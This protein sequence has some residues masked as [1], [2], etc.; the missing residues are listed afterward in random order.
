MA[1]RSKTATRSKRNAPEEAGNEGK[2]RSI[3]VSFNGEVP[4]DVLQFIGNLKKCEVKFVAF[5]AATVGKGM[6][7]KEK[8]TWI[9]TNQVSPS[10]SVSDWLREEE[11]CYHLRPN[12]C[13]LIA[14]YACMRIS[15]EIGYVSKMFDFDETTHEDPFGAFIKALIEESKK[16]KQI[17]LTDRYIEVF[18]ENASLINHRDRAELAKVKKFLPLQLQDLLDKNLHREDPS[19]SQNKAEGKPSIL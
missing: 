7:R 16:G 2:A 15:G 5:V 13:K 8:D 1:T 14:E 19:I 17:L 18:T 10:D 3:A 11:N 4:R 6:T 12:Q 9:N